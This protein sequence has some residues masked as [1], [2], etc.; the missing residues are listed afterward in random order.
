[1][2]ILTFD[3]E[4]WYNHDDYSQDFEWDK[5][6]VRLYEGVD[7]I[8]CALDERNIK[9]SFMCLGWIAE[10]HPSIIRKISDNGHHIG[11]HSYQH[12]L[13]TR[14]SKAEFRE[15]TYKAKSLLEDVSGQAVDAFRV[16]SF[17]ITTSNKWA[18]EILAELGFVYD[19]S[20]FPSQHEF[21]G[22]PGFPASP[23]II[24]TSKGDLKE[25][26]INLGN[27]LGREIVYTGGGYFRIFPY[28][29]LKKMTQASQYIMSYFHP[30]DFDP[31]QPH[32]PQLSAMRQLKNRIGLKGSYKKFCRYISDFEFVD[33]LKAD[34]MIDWSKC[35]TIKLE[36][37]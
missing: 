28:G 29:K 20:V 34:T 7:K 3:I 23:T 9:A 5:F 4:D 37:I 27:V 25:L 21:G 18:F 26:P 8:L 6:E 10:K 17:S 14:F 13:A 11:C 30:S 31:G 33:I 12:Q 1:M 19:C 24:S 16:P 36:D 35:K 15:D 32:M 22:I 2:N